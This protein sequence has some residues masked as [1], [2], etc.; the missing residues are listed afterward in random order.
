MMKISNF[1]ILWDGPVLCV[2]IVRKINRHEFRLSCL[3]NGVLFRKKL[4]LGFAYNLRWKSFL[5]ENVSMGKCYIWFSGAM[6][7]DILDSSKKKE[8]NFLEILDFADFFQKNKYI[9]ME[10]LRLRCAA[11]MLDGPVF[12]C[13]IQ[14]L[15]TCVN[16]HTI[17]VLLI[18]HSN[19]SR[20]VLSF[21]PPYRSISP[22]SFLTSLHPP[23]LFSSPPVEGAP[24]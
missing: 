23:L 11:A 16:K 1:R 5:Y 21:I 7:T 10:H 17:C 13:A 4:A 22:S 12:G 20:Q 2:L 6:F 3:Q 15:P 19:W 24:R 14:W 9:G 8:T 18:L